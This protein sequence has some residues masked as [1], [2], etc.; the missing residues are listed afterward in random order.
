MTISV[1]RA[2]NPGISVFLL[3]LATRCATLA[4][5]RVGA[6]E[7]VV[8]WPGK[9]DGILTDVGANRDFFWAAFRKPS[10]F[11]VWQWSNGTVVKRCELPYTDR[12]FTV[13]MLPNAKWLAREREGFCIGDLKSGKV[14]S[15]W[16]NPDKLDVSLRQASQNG[17]HFAAVAWDE[18]EGSYN[19]DSMHVGLILPEEKMFQ[20]AATLSPDYGDSVSGITSKAIPSNDG[21]FI[22]IPSWDNGV[23]MVDV[24]HK[25]VLWTASTQHL[26]RP[27]DA[28]RRNKVS[29]KGIALD[30]VKI[31]DLAFTPDSKVVYAGG[32]I[33]SD[34]MG[35]T[36]CLWAMNVET[37]EVLSRWE[38]A[39][40]RPEEYS[41]TITTVSVSPDGRYVAAGTVPSGLVFLYSTKDGRRHTIEHGSPATIDFVSFSSD[42]KRLA[43]FAAN[44]VKQ[45]V[46]WKLPAETEKPVSK[47]TDSDK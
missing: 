30:A 29:W 38:I 10:A 2:I 8:P 37:G 43:T 32:A 34:T 23:A 18:V 28:R 5:D 20:K 14:V 42:S 16:P 13:L 4:Q 21:R 27:T 40:S 45:I 31:D 39:D 19:H 6:P 9:T 44:N 22:G 46:I 41:R 33:A 24:V 15:R 35:A 25:K 17:E 11:H 26:P 36:G 47:T 1:F 12:T 3:I 7:R